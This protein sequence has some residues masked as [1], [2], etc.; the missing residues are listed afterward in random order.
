MDGSS[1]MLANDLITLRVCPRPRAVQCSAV[2]STTR[3]H[4]KTLAT[5]M[6]L[7]LFK[8]VAALFVMQKLFAESNL[9]GQA[10]Q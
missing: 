9:Q 1:E 8:S 7:P 10:G 3:H 4:L 5:T 6:K 2:S